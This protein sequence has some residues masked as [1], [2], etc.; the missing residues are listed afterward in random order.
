MDGNGRWAQKRM[1][2]RLAGHRAGMKR[3][4]ALADHI[5]SC[6]IRCLTIF[7]LSTE[8]LGR[9]RE[10]LEGLF[11]LFREYFTEYAAK[12]GEGGVSL[13]V[14]GDLSLVPEDVARLAKESERETAGHDRFLLLAIGYGGRRD[15]VR[16]A[17]AVV[18]SGCA[19]TEDSLASALS[20]GGMPALDLLIRTGK[21]Q[22][23]S[24]FLLFEAAY[25]ELVFSEKLFP[26]FTDKDFDRALRGY[27]GRD[28]RF[29]KIHSDQPCK[30]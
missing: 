28:R 9:P 18:A 11:D 14:I 12:L 20:T 29:G 25:A 21:E 13:R 23:L 30:R 27:A 19:L 1:L 17:N 24:N 26:D 8:N 7:A 10:E 2:P 5:F 6:G 3:M 4:I 16:A 22:R 15:I